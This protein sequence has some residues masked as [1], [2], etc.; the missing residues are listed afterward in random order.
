MDCKFFLKSAS[1]TKRIIFHQ[2]ETKLYVL[3][4]F[5]GKQTLLY[6][7]AKGSHV[8]SVIQNVHRNAT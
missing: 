3:V 8:M 2:S 4:S 6:I 7:R 1:S 5:I